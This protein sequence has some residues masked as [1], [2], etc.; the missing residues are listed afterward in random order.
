MT[1]HSNVTLRLTESDFPAA[2]NSADQAA[3][4]A[5]R[6]YLRLVKAELALLVLGALTTSWAIQ[7]ELGRGL[8]A[9][10]GAVSIG[11]GLLATFAIRATEPDRE[12]FGARAIAESTKTLAW[13]YMTRTQPYGSDLSA[14]QADTLLTR[15]I[16]RLL[17][18]RR[19]V[20]AALADTH[21]AEPQI[22]PRMRETRAMPTLQRKETYLENR[23]RDQQRWYSGKAE[24]AKKSSLRWFYFLIAC[25]GLA[26]VGAVVIVR[27]PDMEFNVSAVLVSIA[28]CVLA[29]LQVRRFQDLAQTYALAAHE[30]GLVLER[31]AYVHTDQELSEFVGDAENAIS[32]E[33]TMW[34]A[35]RDSL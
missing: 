32:R 24:A 5:Q 4:H 14:G 21:T 13:R 16:A 22:T 20:G 18:E 33:H 23:I 17:T 27:W 19:S 30:L 3:I 35:R 11:L 12:W 10:I 7:W 29:W 9:I 34:L 26:V 8:L 1:T 6:S 28:S 2:F 15:E 31:Q 25:Q